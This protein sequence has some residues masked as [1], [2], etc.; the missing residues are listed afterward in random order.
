MGR[1]RGPY[2]VVGKIIPVPFIQLPNYGNSSLGHLQSQR[3]AYGA[4]VLVQ[5][6][7]TEEFNMRAPQLPSFSTRCSAVVSQIA[8][9]RS[10]IYI[11]IDIIYS[12]PQDMYSLYNWSPR[13]CIFSQCHSNCGAVFSTCL[14]HAVVENDRSLPSLLEQAISLA[15]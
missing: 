15:C 5:D 11:Y 2:S 10:Y 6:W 13:V 7:P 9:S 12:R 8:E 4:E 14:L 1:V 3:E